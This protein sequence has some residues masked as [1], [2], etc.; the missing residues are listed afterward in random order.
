MPLPPTVLIHP[1]IGQLST[2]GSRIYAGQH[3]NGY[4]IQQTLLG[5]KSN[6]RGDLGRIASVAIYRA[7]VTLMVIQK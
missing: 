6:L 5:V 3:V 2:C 1:E 4:Q 7:G